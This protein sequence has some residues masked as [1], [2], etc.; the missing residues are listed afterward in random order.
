MQNVDGTRAWFKGLA[1]IAPTPI[2]F[3][4]FIDILSARLFMFQLNYLS[5]Q[6]W[7][8]LT[9]MEHH[10]IFILIVAAAIQVEAG[11]TKA[12]RPVSKL[13]AGVQR[14]IDELTC[15]G[16]SCRFARHASNLLFI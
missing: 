7:G 6:T 8:E 3:H 12:H 9:F 14:L 5:R 13:H 4:T 15:T 16:S 2:E 11:Q 1:L 10:L